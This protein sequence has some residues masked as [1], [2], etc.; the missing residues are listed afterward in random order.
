MA[1]SNPC[2]FA[3]CSLTALSLFVA[4]VVPIVLKD[5]I[6][7]AINN[8]QILRL[9]NS[10]KWGQV[11]GANNATLTKQFYLY[12]VDTIDGNTVNL[13]E[14]PIDLYTEQ[15]NYTELEYAPYSNDSIS[16]Y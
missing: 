9:E 16:Y 2:L 13:K 1:K 7:S 6:S 14:I 3:L 11:P 12:D 4:I 8:D 15:F 10:G 5:K